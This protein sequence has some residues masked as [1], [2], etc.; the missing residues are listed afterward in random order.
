[1]IRGLF[2]FGGVFA[3]D[4]FINAIDVLS[5]QAKVAY[6]VNIE[7]SHY[8]GLHWVAILQIEGK[9]EFFDP[10]GMG[11]WHYRYLDIFSTVCYNSHPLQN[12]FSNTSAH[13]CL[14]FLHLRSHGLSFFHIIQWFKNLFHEYTSLYNGVIITAFKL[15]YHVPASTDQ[16]NYENVQS[17]VLPFLF[18]HNR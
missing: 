8:T 12:Q 15:L 1:M 16:E 5:T 9:F 10:L 18:S 17:S 6:I 4:S 11:P 7:F 2:E 14:L 13:I 3:A